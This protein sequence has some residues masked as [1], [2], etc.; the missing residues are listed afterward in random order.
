MSDRGPIGAAR[1][2]AAER[3]QREAQRHTIDTITSDALDALYR[4]I[5]KLTATIRAFP[6]ANNAA[7]LAH[8]RCQRDEAQAAVARVREWADGPCP[9]RPAPFEIT[10]DRAR[11]YVQ[12]MDEIAQLLAG[13]GPLALDPQEP[14]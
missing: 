8:A 1:R 6:D 4:Q 2:A 10:G 9:T 5:E 13:H 11:G 14:S 3:E 12:A 7:N